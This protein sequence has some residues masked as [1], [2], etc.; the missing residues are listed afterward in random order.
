MTH[1]GALQAA[2]QDAGSWTLIEETEPGEWAPLARGGKLKIVELAQKLNG[3]TKSPDPAIRAENIEA[4]R[5]RQEWIKATAENLKPAAATVAALAAAAKTETPPAG[6]I[7]AAEVETWTQDEYLQA[8]GRLWVASNGR[9]FRDGSE[10]GRPYTTPA[11]RMMTGHPD[12]HQPRLQLLKLRAAAR[13]VATTWERKP[14]AELVKE[15]AAMARLRQ[16]L[17][18]LGADE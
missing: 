3:Q 12:E 8:R 18:E 16:V 6:P 10:T 4:V 14:A 15:W 5:T 2:S 9:D 7:T 13:D 1:Y 17:Q 11:A